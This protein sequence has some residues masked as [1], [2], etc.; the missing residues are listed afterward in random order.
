MKNV[1][2]FCLFFSIFLS[3]T[4][5]IPQILS[6]VS[7]AY[8]AAYNSSGT[9]LAGN[10]YVAGSF[11]GTAE[12]PTGNITST[13][14]T[15]DIFIVKYTPAGTISWIKTATGSYN[16]FGRAI[17]V[18]PNGKF[19][20][21]GVINGTFTFGTHVAQIPGSTPK[22]YV[23]MYDSSG[24]CEWLKYFGQSYYDNI[25]AVAFDNS[26]DVLVH[27]SFG[28]GFSADSISTGGFGNQDVFV[29]KFHRNG[30]ALWAKGMGGPQEDL[31]GD[32]FVD[33]TGD[34]YVTGSFEQT[35]YFFWGDTVAV[36]GS[37]GLRDMFVA[38]ISRNGASVWAKRGGAN[39][40]DQGR[41]VAVDNQFNC[42]VIG[43]YSNA[44]IFEND[45]LDV[46]G[47]EDIFLAK[48]NQSGNLVWVK[49]AGGIEADAGLCLSIDT[50]SSKAF[51]G[52]YLY[53][54]Y[55]GNI[56]FFN[57]TLAA[58]GANNHDIF[59]AKVDA[60]GNTVWARGIG[61][62]ASDNAHSMVPYATNHLV[63][64]GLHS[65]N[66]NF[67]GTIFPA[68]VNL[69]RNFICKV[70]TPLSDAEEK[71]EVPSEFSL[72]Q[73]YP[74][75]FNPGT[76]ISYQLPV[77]SLVRLELFSITGEKVATLVNEELESGYHNYNLS[78][79]ALGLSS[80][81]YFYRMIAGEFVST[82]KLMLIK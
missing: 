41:G 39:G 61:S 47:W 31:P 62:V 78:A 8:R 69:A 35:G 55:Q 1:I 57:T 4:E 24:N 75:P 10:I 45:T 38:K 71:E 19:V 17:A 72:G 67:L 54:N 68:T 80:G 34:V 6:W 27:G 77:N 11:Y 79:S 36:L 3:Y 70:G 5:T 7:G 18:Y 43:S 20:I 66:A 50:S 52:V 82:K 25:V 15:S 48:Y 14:G 16:G 21:A 32:I 81:V 42:Y 44:A 56:Q 63:F 59:I 40:Y 74:N 76:L 49:G 60:D 46:F 13:G 12:F 65:H 30:Y 9:D 53:G 2:R 51:S 64:T 37:R 22:M 73:N 58:L 28:G 26:G 33:R 29:A 23:A